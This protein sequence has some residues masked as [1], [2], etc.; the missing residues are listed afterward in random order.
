[1]EN[2][3]EIPEDYSKWVLNELDKHYLINGYEPEGWQAYRNCMEYAYLEAFRH[4]AQ[5]EGAPP[6]WREF[7]NAHKKL[8]GALDEYINLLS[9]E[10]DETTQ[11]AAI[12]WWRSKRHEQGKALRDRIRDCAD[13]IQSFEVIETAIG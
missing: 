4:L 8:I 13:E 11:Q 3:I 1:M 10:L 7:V 12:H 9:K 2:K 6:L 5:S